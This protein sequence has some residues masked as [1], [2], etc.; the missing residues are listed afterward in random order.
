MASGYTQPHSS[1]NDSFVQLVFLEHL[2]YA[3]P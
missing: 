1:L 3:E 2:L